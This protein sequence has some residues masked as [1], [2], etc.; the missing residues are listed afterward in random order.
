MKKIQISP[1][2]LSADFSQLGNEIK[3]LEDAGADLIHVDVMD[4][5]FVP[6]LTIGPP[7][8]KALKKKFKNKKPTVFVFHTIKGKGIKKFENDP[9]WHAR[10]LVGKEIDIGKKALGI[11]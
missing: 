9:I 3:K 11:K 8:I 4:G 1:S 2:I 6:N 5:H 7:V 10:K